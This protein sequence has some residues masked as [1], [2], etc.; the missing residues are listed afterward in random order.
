MDKNITDYKQIYSNFLQ[1]YK[2]GSVTGEHVG[3]IIAKMAQCFSDYNIKTATNEVEAN[4]KAAEIEQS[5]DPI[6][7]KLM[8]SSKGKIISQATDEYTLYLLNR[9]H[10]QNIEQYINALKYLQ[11]GILNEFAHMG[12]T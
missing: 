1:G 6:T 10:L 5:T 2:Q 3:E 4:V 8:T 9:A 12:I 7:G 11:K